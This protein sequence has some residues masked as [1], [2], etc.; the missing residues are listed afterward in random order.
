MGYTELMLTNELSLQQIKEYLK[1]IQHEADKLNELI[2]NFLDIQ[3]QKASRSSTRFRPVDVRPLMRKVATLFG[4][5]TGKHRICVDCPTCLPSVMG[6]EKLLGR[7]IEMLVS[8]AV[9][10]SPHGGEVFLGATMNASS[11]NI[12]VRDQGIGIPAEEL[13]HVF[14]PF[15]RVDNSD[16]RKFGGTGLGL[17]LVREIALGH[18]GRVWAESSMGKGSTFHVSLPARTERDGQE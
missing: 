1:V 12:Q 6:D 18:G 16:R 15:Y 8:N 5:V 11:I 17:A 14:E 9:K 3:M 2:G 7:M 10:F 13:E 4:D